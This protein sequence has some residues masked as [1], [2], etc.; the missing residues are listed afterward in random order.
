MWPVCCVFFDCIVRRISQKMTTQLC[1]VVA[2]VRCLQHLHFLLCL[3]KSCQQQ[4]RGV[5]SNTMQQILPMPSGTRFFSFV[6]VGIFCPCFANAKQ[7]RFLA[8]VS[9][10]ILQNYSLLHRCS[11]VH[12]AFLER[13]RI[14]TQQWSLYTVS[15][16]V[17]QSCM[18]TDS[19]N[20]SFLEIG[21]W[22]SVGINFTSKNSKEML[23]LIY[24]FGLTPSISCWFE[25]NW[26]IYRNLLQP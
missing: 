26:C 25:Y 17:A 11:D 20:L 3:A 8:Y 21:W 12:R 24:T 2:G 4:S 10:Y 1:F 23:R 19:A 5:I 7:N 9:G 6:F 13:M 14:L 16:S 22:C 18:C 15:Y